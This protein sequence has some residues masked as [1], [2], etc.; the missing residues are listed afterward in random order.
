MSKETLVAYFSVS[1][2]TAKVASL[3]AGLVNGDLFEIK[4]TKPYEK[5]DLDW[6]NKESRTSKE[7]EDPSSRPAIERKVNNF[8][9]YEIIFLGFPIW[10]YSAPR[11]I[12]SFLDSYDFSGKKV[13][14][15]VTSLGTAIDKAET[16][17]RASCK[18]HPDWV[19]GK[20]FGSI[21]IDIIS[22]KSW[23]DSLGV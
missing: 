16:D 21:D 8:E 17:I 5:E 22:V 19:N 18:S 13:I 20:R 23:I 10:W 2:H 9:K 11:I 7:H 15:F 3:L 14:P 12:E 1:G 4:P 6:Q